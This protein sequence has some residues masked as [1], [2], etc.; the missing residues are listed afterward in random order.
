MYTTHMV[1]HTHTHEQSN[2]LLANSY[3]YAETATTATA[4]NS[5]L[6]LLLLIMKFKLKPINFSIHLNELN[7]NI[8]FE[9]FL[10]D[11]IELKNAPNINPILIWIDKKVVAMIQNIFNTI[12]YNKNDE[13][14]TLCFSFSYNDDCRT[15]GTGYS[16]ILDTFIVFEWLFPLNKSIHKMAACARKEKKE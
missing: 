14:E 6:R 13:I 12:N 15:V 5:I 8:Q 7:V 2:K 16:L 10:F 3:C 9:N 1:T 11:W 4:T